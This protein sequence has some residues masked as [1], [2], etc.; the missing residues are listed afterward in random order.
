MAPKKAALKKR[1]RKK[2]KSVTDVLLAALPPREKVRRRLSPKQQLRRKNLERQHNKY[3]YLHNDLLSAPNKKLLKYV[4]RYK[5]QVAKRYN[6]ELETEMESRGYFAPQIRHAKNYS[7]VGKNVKLKVINV[8]DRYSKDRR[9]ALV[10]GK[11][12]GKNKA[13][14][15]VKRAVKRARIESYM[16]ILGIDRE[17]AKGVLE[18]I[19]KK[20]ALSYELK[21]LIY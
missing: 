11:W 19:E 5:A 7:L 2:S 3:H 16:D 21:A 8:I 6:A 13:N 14:A 17:M 10:H 4:K 20:T 9:K 15:L 1:S 12:I 18:L